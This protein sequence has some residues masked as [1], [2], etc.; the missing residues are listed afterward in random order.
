MPTSPGTTGVKSRTSWVAESYRRRLTG[1]GYRRAMTGDHRADPARGRDDRTM[2]RAVV[3][4][5]YGGPEV[6]TVVDVDPGEPGPGEVLV[7]VRAAGVNPA[8]W[9]S[10]TGA[11]GTDPAR[12]PLRL[13]YEAAGVV[14]AVG[15]GV[16]GVR[17]GDAVIAHPVQGA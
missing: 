7:E 6:L 13:G 17:V 8:D 16:D 3:A 11:F 5:A 4:P 9:K 10:Y 1:S 15:P 12:L 2:T 14:V